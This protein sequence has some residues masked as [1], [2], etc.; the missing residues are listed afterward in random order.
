MVKLSLVRVGYSEDKR[1][2]GRS[3]LVLRSVYCTV[4]SRRFSN[5]N[6]LSTAADSQILMHC[7]RPQI[8][9]C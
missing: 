1:R 4:D 5:T 3:G 6:A 9:T 2:E 7:Q 8:L